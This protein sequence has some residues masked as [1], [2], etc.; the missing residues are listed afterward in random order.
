MLTYLARRLLLMIPTLLGITL[1]VFVV[2]AASPGGLTVQSLVDTQGLEPEARKALE[3]YYNKL[4]GLDQ[5]AP[6]QY[7]RWLNNISP[8]GFVFDDNGDVDSFSL[9]KGSDFGQ[10]FIYGRP[11]TE[12]LKE[13]VPITLL[14]NIITIPIIY[15]IAITIGVRAATK[16]GEIFDVGSGFIMLGLWSVPTMLAGVLLMGYFSNDQ[17]WHIF[18]TSGLSYREAYDM[19]FMPH[20]S[21]PLEPIKLMLAILLGAFLMVLLS[22]KVPRKSRALGLGLLGLLLGGLFA[23]NMAGEPGWF[24]IGG[25]SLFIGGVFYALGDMQY[26]SF[27]T[28]TMGMIGMFIGALVASIMMEGEF[29]RGF[30]VDRIWH[31]VL[32]IICLTYG[33]FAFLTKLARTS[34]LENLL[35]DYARTARAKGVAEKDVLWRH[36]FRNSLLPLITVSATLLPGL[37][38]GS[39]I[40]ESIFSIDGM[41]KLS[42]EAVKLKDR[43]MVL[44]LTL[45]SGLLTLVGYLIAD[46]FYAIVDPRIS[47][48]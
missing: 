1:V 43:E 46:I 15:L 23:S 7:L 21:S 39:V 20:W 14:L 4:Y 13:R 6:V 42:I 5:P 18:P 25:L 36:V 3:D 40:V 12:L 33:G 34:V 35:S 28:L 27:R 45:I 10:S 31:L 26:A 48:D 11:V 44:S 38:G 24:T 17:Y 19:P 22:N 47:Y 32:P 2:M 30:L 37:L 29:I 16:R 8:V 9:T 41:G